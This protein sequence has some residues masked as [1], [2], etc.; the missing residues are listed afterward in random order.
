VLTSV[1]KGIEILAFFED[2]SL[3]PSTASV[4]SLHSRRSLCR[5]SEAVNKKFV[6]LTK[7]RFLHRPHLTRARAFM[8]AS[9]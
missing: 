9:R 5:T 8:D 6:L 3:R 7:V 1:G 2:C 4:K